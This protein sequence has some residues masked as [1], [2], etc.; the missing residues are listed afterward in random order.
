MRAT[1]A[2]EAARADAQNP[3]ANATG[4][5]L[6]LAKLY[7]DKRRLKEVQS[8][9]RKADVKREILPDYTPYVEG[10]I[11]AGRG[12]QDEVLMT[13]MVWRIDA[14]DFAGALKI[15]AYALK[16]KLAM[17]DQYQ[18]T[19]ACIIAEEFAEQALKAKDAGR[20]FDADTLMEVS[21]LTDG[22]D[23]PDE[24]QAKLLKAI[25]YGLTDSNPKGALALFRRAL[26]LHDKCGVKKDIERLERD[27]RKASLESQN[28]SSTE[29][30]AGPANA[31][32]EAEEQG[33]ALAGEYETNQ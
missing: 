22:H 11:G 5:E 33:H 30:E 16:H 8:I 26:E 17:P 28:T 27:L 3:L 25:A 6:M 24:V 4:Y 10:V 1:A 32:Q 9:E 18:R 7:T 15:A 20:V 21:N 13:I 29:Q 23:M 19:T 14:G 2:V 12:A 31:R